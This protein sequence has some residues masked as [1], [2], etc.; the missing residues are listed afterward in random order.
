ML[1]L[2]QSIITIKIIGF[3]GVDIKF[4]FSDPRFPE[5]YRL[6]MLYLMR[7]QQ[8]VIFLGCNAFRNHDVVIKVETCVWVGVLVEWIF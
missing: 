5:N 3:N 6:G 4:N 8:S 1:E 2:L 7:E